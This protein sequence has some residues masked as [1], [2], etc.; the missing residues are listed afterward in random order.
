MKRFKYAARTPRGDWLFL[1]HEERYYEHTRRT[2][3]RQ[4]EQDYP[5]SS[6]SW[7]AR[8]LLSTASLVDVLRVSFFRGA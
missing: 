6:I 3:R 7:T 5:G 2:L 8:V 1:R 4:V